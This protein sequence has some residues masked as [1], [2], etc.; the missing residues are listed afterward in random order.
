MA[1]LTF[2]SQQSDIL[3]DVSENLSSAKSSP[4]AEPHAQTHVQKSPSIQAISSSEACIPE[5]AERVEHSYQESYQT[6]VPVTLAGDDDDDEEDLYT[7]SPSGKAKLETAIAA[8]KRTQDE[9]VWQ[10]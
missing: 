6:T 2:T 3:I 5:S 4:Q 7:V 1:E 9:Q 8:S 10:L